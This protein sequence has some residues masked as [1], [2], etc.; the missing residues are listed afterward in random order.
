VEIIDTLLGFRPA[1]SAS[2]VAQHDVDA[3]GFWD[4][5]DVASFNVTK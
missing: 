3:N 4:A 2:R 1:P 5:G